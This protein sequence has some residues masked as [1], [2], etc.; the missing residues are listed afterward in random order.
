MKVMI[1][2]MFKIGAYLFLILMILS[3]RCSRTKTN[4]PFKHTLSKFKMLDQN[5]KFDY[6]CFYP[7]EDCKNCKRIDTKKDHPYFRKNEAMSTSIGMLPDTSK[8]YMLLYCNAAACY[9]PSLAIFTKE[10]KL[11]DDKEINYELG[12]DCGFK[13]SN[14][15]TL[16]SKNQLQS[17]YVEE[18]Y[19]C[20]SLGK[21]TPGTWVKF[22]ET[23]VY[24]VNKNGKII[25]EKNK[26]YFFQK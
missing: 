20:D 26:K 21:P 10:G 3:F 15:V 2:I 25:E 23:Y 22:E 13:N 18:S 9:V 16:K 8:F 17:E 24:S 4:K 5:F 1:R 7:E 19:Q 6:I 11:I 14:K 12:A